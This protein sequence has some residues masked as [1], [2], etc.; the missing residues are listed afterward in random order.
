M[1][2]LEEIRLPDPVR[3]RHEHEAGLEGEIERRIGTE[4]AEG[5]GFDD[6]PASLIGMIR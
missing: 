5:G 2:G 6:Q 1:K 3:A 4:V